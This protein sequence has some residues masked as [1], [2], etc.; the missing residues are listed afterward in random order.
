M[1]EAEVT[2]LPRIRVLIVDDT[3]VARQLLAHLLESHPRIEVIGAVNDGNAALEFLQRKRPDVV[4]MDIHMPG[5]DGFETTRRIMESQQPLPIIICTAT[6]DPA[7]VAI[8]FRAM[9]AGALACLGKPVSHAHPEYASL[10]RQLLETITVMSEVRVVRR[11]PRSRG[12][13]AVPVPQRLT[14][15]TRIVGIGASTGGPPVLQTILAGLSKDFPMPL[16]IVQHIAHGFLGGFVDWLNQTSSLN[17]QIAAHGV[18]PQ[19]GHAY[20]A[21]DDFHMGV[22]AGGRIVLARSEPEGGLRPAASHLFRS[23][24]QNHGPDAIGVLLTGMGRDGAAE[25]KLMRDRGAETIAQDRETSVVHGMPGAAIA[26][27]GAGKVLPADRIADALL[28]LAQGRKPHK[29][30]RQQEGSHD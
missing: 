22:D 29:G 10:A 6:S 9:E 1:S 20:V 13:V 12:P 30:L 18:L 8:A 25:L 3:A 21:P 15:G 24:A 28:Q 5:L 27:G 7:E 14:A 23:L 2:P 16:L 26:L 11:W 17:V 19:P 4:V